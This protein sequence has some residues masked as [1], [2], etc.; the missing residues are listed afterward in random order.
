MIYEGKA[1]TVKEIEGGIAQLDFDLQGESVNKFNRLTI[2]ELHAATDA[3]K[4][5]SQQPQSQRHFQC[6]RGPTVPDSYG[7]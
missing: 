2:E 3:L 7:H 4:A 5:Q 1:I 6:R